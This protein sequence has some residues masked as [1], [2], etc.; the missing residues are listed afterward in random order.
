VVILQAMTTMFQLT[1]AHLLHIEKRMLDEIDKGLNKRT[2][3]SACVKSFVTYVH[4]LPSGRED[5]V[6]LALDLGGTNFRVILVELEAGSRSV[7]MK[8]HKHQVGMLNDHY[9][10]LGGKNTIH[11]AKVLWRLLRSKSYRT[12]QSLNRPWRP[13]LSSPHTQIRCT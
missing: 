13:Q 12:F 11:E 7:K 2:H 1:D 9:A 10:I 6:F 3:D 8:S 4:D 5:G